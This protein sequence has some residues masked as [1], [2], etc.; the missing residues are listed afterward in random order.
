[1][2]KEKFFK[3]AR[4]IEVTV[5]TRTLTLTPREFKSGNVGFGLVGKFSMKI[6]GERVTFTLTCNMTANKSRDWKPE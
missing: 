4:P 3:K 6:N 5:G 1:M 2:T